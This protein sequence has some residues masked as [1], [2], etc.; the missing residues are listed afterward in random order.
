[1][2]AEQDEPNVPPNE[3]LRPDREPRSPKGSRLS[4]SPGRKW[5]E[6]RPN[7]KLPSRTAAFRESPLIF[8]EH[9]RRS[10]ACAR[11]RRLTHA[12]ARPFVEPPSS[13]SLRSTQQSSAPFP[14]TIP[15]AE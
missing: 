3:F 15:A 6:A 4:E 13:A 12:P 1:S 8:A 5:H 9:A 14:D 7:G 11:T 2:P 10:T